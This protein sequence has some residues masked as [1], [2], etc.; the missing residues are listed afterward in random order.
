MIYLTSR[1][2]TRN[3]KYYSICRCST[4]SVPYTC[5]YELC[6]WNCEENM[7]NFEIKNPAC[8]ALARWHIC[9]HSNDQIQWDLHLRVNMMTLVPEAVSRAGISNCIPQN[10]MGCNYFSL[11]K[12]PGPWFNIKMSSYQYRKS[13][14]GDKTV[15]ISSYLH[16]GISYT[17]KMTSLY[18]IRALLLAP[19][20][21]NINNICLQTWLLTYMYFDPIW[22]QKRPTNM[23]PGGPYATHF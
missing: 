18:W 11:P 3:I 23:A 19:K 22:D 13:H 1:L 14:C 2:M 16:N 9:R 12:I 4:S 21:P 17:G 5:I 8:Y 7:F 20:S 15:V 6:I 10:T